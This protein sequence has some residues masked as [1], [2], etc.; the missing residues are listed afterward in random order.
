MTI[1]DARPTTG[2][3]V[4]QGMIAGCLC[5]FTGAVLA[6]ILLFIVAQFVVK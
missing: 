5:V 6:I 3:P 2:N 1:K 4:I